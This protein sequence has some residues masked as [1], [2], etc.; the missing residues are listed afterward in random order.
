M[1][2][3]VK[4]PTIF[5]MVDILYNHHYNTTISLYPKGTGIM[6]DKTINKIACLASI[7]HCDRQVSNLKENKRKNEYSPFRFSDEL[8]YWISVREILKNKML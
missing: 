5:E 2:P 6:I 1:P 4:K 8:C 7:E 3:R